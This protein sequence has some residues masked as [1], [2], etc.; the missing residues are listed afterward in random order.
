MAHWTA[1]GA[2]HPRRGVH[3]GLSLVLLADR[4]AG[5]RLV[6]AVPAARDRGR[7]FRRPAA[8]LA[9][10]DPELVRAT[11]S[12][13]V[14]VTD[15]ASEAAATAWWEDM[16]AAGGEGVVVKPAANQTR[17]RRGVVQPG[18]KVAAASTCG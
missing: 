2:G 18:L 16:T 13:A 17:G 11:R 10:A 4:R 15:P 6:R 8:R 1:T 12:L 9:E 14:D 3:A 5:G 7:D